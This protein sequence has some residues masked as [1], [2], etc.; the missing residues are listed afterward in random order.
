MDGERWLLCGG[1]DSALTLT[2]L[3]LVCQV[4]DL[5]FYLDTQSKVASSIHKD[6]IQGGTVQIEAKPRDTGATTASSSSTTA[7]TRRKSKTKR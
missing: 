7:T 4:R 3:S 2:L 1:G 5:M 6:D